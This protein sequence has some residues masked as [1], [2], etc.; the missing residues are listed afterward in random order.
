MDM[1]MQ[2]RLGPGEGEVQVR[3]V[4]KSGL[5]QRDSSSQH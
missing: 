4:T 2:V 3:I 5:Y 1:N